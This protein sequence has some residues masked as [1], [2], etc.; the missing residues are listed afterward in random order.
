MAAS[1]ITSSDYI[2][3]TTDQL[4]NGRKYIHAEVAK[5]TEDIMIRIFFNDQI[6]IRIQSAILFKFFFFFF[7]RIFAQINHR[8]ANAMP[9]NKQSIMRSIL[10]ISIRKG[11]RSGSEVQFLENL[12]IT[13]GVD[14]LVISSFTVPLQ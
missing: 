7:F 10:R 1:S 2:N 5:N 13:E 6:E 9:K 12:V 8:R 14:I 4:I 3:Y 11:S